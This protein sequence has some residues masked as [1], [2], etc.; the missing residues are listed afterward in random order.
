MAATTPSLESAC[1]V[2]RLSHLPRSPS[3]A[4]APAGT[5]L[6]TAQTVLAVHPAPRPAY[7]LRAQI[8]ISIA[9]LFAGK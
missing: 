9:N 2:L 1:S 8:T 6:V 3:I 5:P 7:S 4:S